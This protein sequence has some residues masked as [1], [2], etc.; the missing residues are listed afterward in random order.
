MKLRV[1]LLLGTVALLALVLG[2]CAAVLISASFDAMMDSQRASAL[3]TWNSVR[4]TLEVVG[5]S[6]SGTDTEDLQRALRAM[7][8]GGRALWDGVELM[9]GNKRVYGA[10]VD[11][12][13]AEAQAG[14]C[15]ITAFHRDEAH[16]LQL[17]GTV[18]AGGRELELKL[19][20]DIT[21]L[22][23]ARAAQL[24]VFRRLLLAALVIGAAGSWL[25]AM[26]LTRPLTKLGRAS[27]KLAAGDLTSRAD[28]KSGD[29]LEVLAHEFNA[30]AGELETNMGKMREFVD[31][32]T[33]FMGSFA[34]ELKTPM[35][36]I[37]GYSDLLRR[38]TLTEEEAREAA[39]Y[40]FSE[41]RR[42]EALSL[43]L[44]DLILLKK[45]DFELIPTE[46]KAILSSVVR[47]MRP[48]LTR[49]GVTLRYRAGEGRCLLEPDL[50]KSLLINLVDNARKAMDN[51][52]AIF[53]LAELTEE[54]CRFSVTDNGRGIPEADLARI[55]EA[56]YR[57]D[58]SRSRAQGGVGLG[59]A[60]CDEIARLHHGSLTVRSV[61]GR[62]TVI[63]AELK[64]GRV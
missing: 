6:G 45:E 1:K 54:G 9:E 61:L 17:S 50:T 31:R 40:I 8:N 56:F 43:K 3:R 15:L 18:S 52:G 35:T 25:M 10:G 53:I 42:L 55:T 34:H 27:R 48:A 49:A 64:G 38:S 30:M 16:Y 12:E 63:T 36:S 7:E 19:V 39:N 28:V 23:E 58:K 5:A 11:P 26:L 51:G 21:Q 2:I 37:I 57:V 60:L 46:P 41:S 62:G 4:T 20:S 33:A 44:Q 22:F 32:Q 47:L 24:A 59:L 13:E 14:S 29:E